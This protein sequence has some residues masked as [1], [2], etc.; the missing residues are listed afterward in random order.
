V[1]EK[2]WERRVCTV[3]LQPELAVARGIRSAF[4]RRY[5]A[6]AMPRHHIVMANMTVSAT[7]T[8]L[9]Y[10]KEYSGLMKPDAGVT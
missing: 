9:R 6:N 3:A 8:N 4:P 5:L 10:E 7:L 2:P 1:K